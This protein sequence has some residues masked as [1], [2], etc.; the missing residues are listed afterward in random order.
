MAKNQKIQTNF[1]AGE[2]S[3]LM[4]SRV[5]VSKYYNGC[6]EAW[7]VRSGALAETHPPA[8]N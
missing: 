3:P 2:L 1:T 6:I 4:S 5:D 7:D 8:G